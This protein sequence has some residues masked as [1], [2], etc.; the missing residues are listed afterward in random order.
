VPTVRTSAVAPTG[1]TWPWSCIAY[2]EGF[3]PANPAT[4]TGNGYYGGLQFSLETWQA[5]GGVGMPQDASIAEQEA[6]AER[7]LAGQGWR[8]WPNTSAMCGL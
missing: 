8:A 5:Y 4:D 3:P 7:V 2:H 6:V 1:W